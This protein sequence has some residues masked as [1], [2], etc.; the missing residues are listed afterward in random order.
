MKRRYFPWRLF[1]NFF[2]SLVIL[3][4]ILNIF[5][6][7][8]ASYIFKFGFYTLENLL[9][10]ICFFLFSLFGSAVFAYRLTLPMRRV[11][12]KALRMG[13]KKLFYELAEE[14][15]ESE[16]L[17]Q[18]E[19][20][21]YY[22][23]E[24]ALDQIRKKLKRRREQLAHER[25]ETQSLISSI[26]DGVVSVGPDGKLLYFNSGFAAQF[27]NRAQLMASAESPLQLT[28]VLRDNDILQLFDS[29]LHTGIGGSLQKEMRTLIGPGE[30]VFSIT[31]NPL[32]DPKTKEIFGVMGI[33]H[34]ISEMKKAERIR[35]EFVE[36]A[37]HELRTPLTSIKGYL[38][39]LKEDYTAGRLEQAGSFLKIISKNVDRLSDLVNDLLMI[40]TLEH[41]ASPE[42]EL[43]NPGQIT[44]DVIEKLSRL[45]KEKNI[46][47]QVNVDGVEQLKADPGKLEQVLM[48]LIGNAI[49]YIPEGGKVNVTWEQSPEPRAIV[50]RVKD[51]GPGIA[52]EHQNRLFERFYRVDKARSREVGGT[53][54]GLA[55]VK[56]IMQS[57]G[58]NVALR[59]DI[60]LGAEFI[61]QF[62]IKN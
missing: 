30:H 23:L 4:N 19:P 26:E 5:T 32:R 54:L 62:P 25:E 8:I 60:G 31:I 6:I 34:D 27:L 55:I 59:S 14:T 39:T 42:L 35:I 21:E 38:E 10:T 3:L 58:G 20:G 18:S 41:G 61:C 1:W 50:L 57:H 40:S 17:F 47:L 37:S 9:F 46:L 13:N 56:H 29:A 52:S 49:K 16:D 12:L 15:A 22:E 44:A 43:V 53:G 36:N 48:N 2:G 33:F 7:G 51:N 11:I 28:Q 45:A 24:Q